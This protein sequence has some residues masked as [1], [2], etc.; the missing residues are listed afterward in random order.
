MKKLSVI[1]PVYNTE[2]YLSEC[3]SSVPVRDGV[4]IILV[5]DGSTDGSAALC[6]AIADER[7]DVRV[8][9]SDN[10]GL[11]GARNLGL[12]CGGSEYVMFLDS[13]DL[14]ADGAID[15][16]LSVIDTYS[17]EIIAFDFSVRKNGADTKHKGEVFSSDSVFT[18]SECPEYLTFLPNAW[19]RVYKRVLFERAEIEFPTRLRYEDL[20]SVPAL[21]ASADS[22]LAVPDRLY[23]YRQRSD[24]IMTGTDPEKNLDVMKAFE[25]LLSRFDRLGLREKHCRELEWLAI[26][27]AFLAA[28]VRVLSGRDSTAVSAVIKLT[29]YVREKFPE[30]ESNAYLYKLNPRQKVLFHSLAEGNFRLAKLLVR[31]NSTLKGT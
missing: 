31:L 1:I 27:H 19:S 18:A 20:A 16:V 5:N 8:I 2:K 26:E 6:N 4:E 15:K 25:I 28:S 12:F 14:L 10:R 30:F 13:D 3:V 17:P 29:E 24:S 23:I 22:I 7:N 21:I 11:G 9:H